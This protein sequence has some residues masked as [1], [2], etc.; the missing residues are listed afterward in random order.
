M[1]VGRFDWITILGLYRRG[2]RSRLSPHTPM[3][4]PSGRK[5]RRRKSQPHCNFLCQTSRSLRLRL[6]SFDFLFTHQTPSSLKN[7]KC[8][9][10]FSDIYSTYDI[11]IIAIF[12][13]H[14]GFSIYT[15]FCFFVFLEI[16]N[17]A[18]IKCSICSCET[19]G[20]FIA[21]DSTTLSYTLS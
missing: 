6:K 5:R 21:D 2:S 9:R 14:T 19:S 11:W 17:F 15:V 20:Q 3:V 18:L 10:Q 4:T 12:L 13:R 1:V 8:S 16:C 7:I